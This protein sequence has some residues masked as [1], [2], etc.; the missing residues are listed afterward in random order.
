MAKLY[1]RGEGIREEPNYCTQDF[2]LF[3]FLT[4]QRNAHVNGIL[5]L[6]PGSQEFLQYV[7]SWRTN[8]QKMEFFPGEIDQKI[9]RLASSC[10]KVD[11]VT[12]HLL[13]KET[14]LAA[15]KLPNRDGCPLDNILTDGSLD[16][17]CNIR[18]EERVIEIFPYRNERSNPT[19]RY[20][21]DAAKAEAANRFRY[22]GSLR[23]AL[24]EFQQQGFTFNKM[25]WPTS[26][27][28]VDRTYD[29][30]KGFGPVIDRNIPLDKLFKA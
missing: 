22:D 1:T 13:V 21:Y 3:N 19:W 16:M 2:S 4:S 27:D 10:I 11:S 28:S 9:A 12:K 23:D 25:R 30:V 20:F 18:P 14:E 15:L 5:F 24:Q 26:R 8:Y 29:L 17:A 7:E 6:Q